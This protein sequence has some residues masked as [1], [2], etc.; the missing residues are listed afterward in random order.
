MAVLWIALGVSSEEHWVAKNGKDIFDN[1]DLYI[2]SFYFILTTITTVGYGDY[3]GYNSDEY[4]FSM[5]VEFV[6]LSFFSFLMGSINTML[7]GTQRF[8]DLI[9]QRLEEL[10]MWMRKLELASKKKK[11]PNRLY[12]DI[13]RN[14]ESAFVY[15]F[16]LL[17]EEF[18]FY[19]FLPPHL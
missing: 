8:E 16:N 17:I 3:S 11:L 7:S 2:D 12:R 9:N 15:D 10:D 18:D 19:K 1:F 6:G 4:L 5:F 13:K 14:V